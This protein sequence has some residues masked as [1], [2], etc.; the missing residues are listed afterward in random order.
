MSIQIGTV[1][2]SSGVASAV[3]PPQQPASTVAAPAV[4]ASASA[5]AQIATASAAMATGSTFSIMA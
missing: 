3:W 1:A 5:D 2:A 4:A